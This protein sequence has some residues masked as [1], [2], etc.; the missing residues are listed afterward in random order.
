VAGKYTDVLAARKELCEKCL[1]YHS[2]DPL[3]YLG[4]SYAMFRIAKGDVRQ[5]AIGG[6][7]IGRH[8]DTIS[9]RAAMLSGTLKGSAGIPKEWIAMFRP[10]ESLERIRTKAGRIAHFITK[11][12]LPVMRERQAIP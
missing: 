5:A 9:G 4:L 2:I 12:K 3:E 10:E 6:T 8:S 1:H 7:N 11:R